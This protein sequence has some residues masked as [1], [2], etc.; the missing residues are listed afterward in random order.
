[1]SKVLNLQK[2]QLEAVTSEPQVAFSGG[3]CFAGSCGG[4]PVKTTI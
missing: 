2:V 4:G 1:M 3:S